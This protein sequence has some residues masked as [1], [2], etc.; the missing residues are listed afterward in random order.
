M[1][2]YTPFQ[3]VSLTPFVFQASRYE[4]YKDGQKINYGPTSIIV[5]CTRLDGDRVKCIIG[6]NDL[7]DKLMSCEFDE[8]ITLHDR[9][10][11]LS[12]PEETN[13]HIPIVSML[14]VTTGPTCYSRNYQSIEPVVGSIYTLNGYVVK[15]SFTMANP[16]RLIELY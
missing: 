9:M 4:E 6:N 8:C 7:Y 14:Q 3:Q 11:M 12:C 2:S 5:R 15:M 13:A 1:D 10:L 16:E